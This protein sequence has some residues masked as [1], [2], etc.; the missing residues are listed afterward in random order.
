[1]VVVPDVR[2]MVV[3][4]VVAEIDVTDYT[5]RIVDHGMVYKFAAR[6]VEVKL[7]SH[8]NV[9]NL[10]A[11]DVME[12]AVVRAVKCRMTTEQYETTEDELVHHM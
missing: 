7:D 11:L 1:M 3:V 6:V 8:D 5:I 10:A 4:H 2:T 12:M 9:D